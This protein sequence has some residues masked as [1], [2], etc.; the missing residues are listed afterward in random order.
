V[1]AFISHSSRNRSTA[2][3]IEAGLE[4]EGLQVWLDDSEIKLGVLLGKELQDSIRDS[5]VV[6]LLWSSFAAQS[7]W[8]AAE[9]LTAFHLDRFIV[10]CTLDDTPLPQCLQ[11]SVYLRLRRV[12]P[13]MIDR[14][15]RAIRQ[16]PRKA[17]PMAP[18]M[19]A[20]SPQLSAEIARINDGQ[21]AVADHLGAGDLPGARRAQSALNR[22]MNR[23]LADWPFDSMMVNLAGYHLKNAYMVGHWAEIQAG[24]AP[25]DP[26]LRESEQRFFETLSLDPTEPSALNGVG[27]I[28]F[29]ERDLDAAEFFV[30]A[31]IEQS[32]R[33]G[34]SYPA[35]ESDLALIRRF[36]PE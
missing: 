15:G 4:R 35:A 28:L 36:K 8:I 7:R 20:E 1:D 2:R 32:R 13:S 5:G 24:R 18:M 16:S 3:R 26:L 25:A 34:V 30:S 31:A 14:L 11:G 27:N 23:G 10:P 19:R 9:W 29:F 21:M 33:R 6:V 22:R 12:T 17:N